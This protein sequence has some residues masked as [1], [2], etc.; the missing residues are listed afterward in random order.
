[1]QQFIRREGKE[2]ESKEYEAASYPPC[3]YAEDVDR[4]DFADHRER[5]GVRHRWC[6][7]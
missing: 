6:D 7:L 1:M 5:A 2:R 4:N 3:L